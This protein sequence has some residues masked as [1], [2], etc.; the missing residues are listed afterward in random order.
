MLTRP[1]RRTIAAALAAGAFVLVP[2]GVAGAHHP[3]VTAEVVCVDG[4][5][6][7][8]FTSTAWEG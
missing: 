1:L 2:A 7:V 3:T 5:E 4:V 8:A 6:T